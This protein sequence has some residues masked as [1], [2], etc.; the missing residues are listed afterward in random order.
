MAEAGSAGEE[1]GAV[2]LARRPDGSPSEIGLDGI[3][4]LLRI[5]LQARRIS[6]AWPGSM[7]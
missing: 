4:Q 2:A 6:T 1:T 7:V 5:G 3:L